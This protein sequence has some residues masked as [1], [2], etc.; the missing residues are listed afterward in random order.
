MEEKS[1]LETL[2]AQKER[3]V[4]RLFL[5]M[6]E[7]LFIFGLPAVAAF[8]LGRAYDEVTGTKAYTII[9]LSTAFIFS[10]ILLVLR[11]RSVTKKLKKLD[12][13]IAEEEKG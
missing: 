5:M 6:F 12:E 3:Y 8:F 11:L 2:K 4:H 7:I 9:F 10:W 1:K 13:E